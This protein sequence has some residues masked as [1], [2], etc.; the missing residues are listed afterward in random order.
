MS[1]GFMALACGAA[2]AAEPTVDAMQ[3]LKSSDQARGGGFSGLVW[4]V[5]TTSTGTGMEDQTPQVLRLKAIDTASVAEVLEPPNS[6]GSKILQSERNMWISKPGLKKPV[7][8]SPRQRLTGQAAIGDIAATNYARDYSATYLRDETVGDEPCHVLELTAVN[9]QTTYD[10]I[11]Y[12]VSARRGVALRA[13]F[14]SL[15]GK[16][17]KSAEFEYGNSIIANGKSLAFVSRMTIADALTDARTTL[18]YRRVKP[19]V[20][21]PSEFD[22]GNLQ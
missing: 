8:I 6:K 4:E 17:L 16:R 7:A 19:Q 3:W 11:V 22:V 5:H 20:L 1:L 14:L 2:G 13:D 18:D 10:R 9:R 21:S 15:S 12:W